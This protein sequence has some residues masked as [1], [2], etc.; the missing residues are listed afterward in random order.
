MSRS[1]VHADPVEIRRFQSSLRQFNHQLEAIA[2]RLKSQLRSLGT[3]WQDS[4]Y[5]KF[6]Q[7][8]DEALGAFR[9]YLNNSEEYLR[10]LDK[11]AEPLERYR[12]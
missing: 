11:K 9:S 5:H 4:E 8:L 3:S 2:T 10:Y 7:Q 1:G 6:E 12:G